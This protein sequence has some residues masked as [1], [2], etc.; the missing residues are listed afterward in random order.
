ME[1]FENPALSSVPR[2]K[3]PVYYRMNGA[4]Y[5]VKTDFLFSGKPIYGERS[6][7]YIMDRKHSIDIDDELD[8][9]LAETILQMQQARHH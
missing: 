7:A 6:Y 5:I 3:L 2:Q 1:Q 9:A 8:F 4:I